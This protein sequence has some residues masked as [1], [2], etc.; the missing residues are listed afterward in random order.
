MLA[1]E[2]FSLLTANPLPL[3]PR[4][5]REDSMGTL[6]VVFQAKEYA[7][8]GFVTIVLGAVVVAVLFVRKKWQ[9]MKTLRACPGPLTTFPFGNALQLKLDSAGNR[10]Y[11]I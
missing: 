6:D 11:H 7:P 4:H 3:I 10:P 5:H 8:L 1:F 9:Y 2:I